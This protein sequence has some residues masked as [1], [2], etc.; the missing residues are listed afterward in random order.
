MPPA[1]IFFDGLVIDGTVF[2]GYY[3]HDE[4][5]KFRADSPHIVQLANLEATI[6]DESGVYSQAEVFDGIY[7]ANNLGKLT[8]APQVRYLTGLVLGNLTFEGF[9]YLTGTD[10]WKQSREYTRRAW[11]ATAK[12]LTDIIISAVR[13]ARLWGNGR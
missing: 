4:S 8:A 6:P 7:M 11:S 10:V 2:D 5:G 12:A 9:T 1:S 13:T 3:Y